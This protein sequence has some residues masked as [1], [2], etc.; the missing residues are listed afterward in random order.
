MM[1]ITNRSRS[2]SPGTL[3]FVLSFLFLWSLLASGASANPDVYDVL[4]DDTRV[5]QYCLGDLDGDSKD[6]L[7][8][9]YTTGDETR[10]TLFRADG[11][12]W[13][14]WWDDNGSAT[15]KDGIAPGSMEAVDTNGDGRLE[16]LTYYLSQGHNAMAARVWSLDNRDPGSPAM[17]VLLEDVTS[18]PGYPLLGM[19]E[20]QFSITFLKMPSADGDGYRR[21]YC[22]NGDVF[23]NC[24]EVKW[25]KQ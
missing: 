12:H 15:M 22:W 4:P 20:E 8:V 11:G 25:E 17:D 14:R 21:V 16:I 13:S 9:L 7:A 18:P 5:L 19:E 24:L 2:L 1:I 6:E 10:I 3:C 23:E